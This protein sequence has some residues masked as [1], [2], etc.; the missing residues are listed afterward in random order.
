M[1]PHPKNRVTPRHASSLDR[2][3]LVR[4]LWRPRS[5]ADSSS[6]HLQTCAEHTRAVHSVTL[7]EQWVGREGLIIYLQLC[8][9][10]LKSNLL[11][12]TQRIPYGS[13]SRGRKWFSAFVFRG[14]LSHLDR[15]RSS[16]RAGVALHLQND[17][18]QIKLKSH[19]T[20]DAS[21]PVDLAIHF[22]KQNEIS[23]LWTKGPNSTAACM[24][25]SSTIATHSKQDLLGQTR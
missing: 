7:P 17:P 16:W 9:R 11:Q 2:W 12:Q 10:T 22:C 4:A 24:A 14:P 3:G 18:F 21:R 6:H 15:Q 20:T 1:K 8:S 19:L 5:G 23:A 13:E 25:T